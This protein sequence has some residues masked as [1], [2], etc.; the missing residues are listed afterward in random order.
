MTNDKLPMTNQNQN[1][2]D[3]NK[4]NL[5]ERTSKFGCEVIIFVKKIKCTLFKFLYYTEQL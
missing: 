3:K 1:Q 4:Y 2:N 5:A